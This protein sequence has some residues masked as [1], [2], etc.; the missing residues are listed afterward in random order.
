ME[1]KAQLLG[2]KLHGEK[3]EVVVKAPSYYL[4]VKLSRFL[5]ILPSREIRESSN[6][7]KRR[8]HRA[9]SK[10]QKDVLLLEIMAKAGI[11][12]EQFLKLLKDP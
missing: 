2:S 12:K 5:S 3:V 9:N 1:V 7:N 4:G 11:T 10:T 6:P 8:S